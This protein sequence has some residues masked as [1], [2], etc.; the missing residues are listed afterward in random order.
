[1]R[2]GAR[3]ARDVI[4][5]ALEA[6][7]RLDAILH[8]LNGPLDTA[9]ARQAADRI[10][11][12]DAREPAN[13]IDP[14]G[15]RKAAGGALAGVPFLVKA[16]TAA[17]APIVARLRA[18][19]AIPIGVST[20][21]RPGTDSQTHGWNGTGFTRNPWD[22]AR[23]PGGSSAGAAAAVAAGV[24]P[25]ATGGDSG[26][27]LRIPAAFC[28]VT[29]F[30]G[31]AGRIPRPGRAVVDLA[32]AGLIGADLDD[33]VAATSLVS[34]PDRLDPA[35]LPGWPV[36]EPVEAPRVGYLATFGGPGDRRGRGVADPAVDAVV[37]SRLSAA[38]ITPVEVPFE[39]PDPGDAWDVFAALDAGRA[40]PD[41]LL[42]PAIAA[43][44]RA[45]A[46]VWDLFEQ[47]DALVTPTTL[48]V[49]HPFD[50]PVAGAPFVGDLCW[51]FN[52]TGNPA[53]SVPAGLVDGLPV[54]VQVVA[55]HG[56]DDIVVSLGRRLRAE[57]P[58]AP[59]HA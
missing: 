3:S 8:F 34:G 43:R 59:H 49:A 36:P 12:G 25:L 4:D 33:V 52:L 57:L 19:G 37:R 16:G 51:D 20:R 48:T 40:V 14:G 24:V 28:G 58:Q 21:N 35:A 29:G 56:R 45:D 55:A 5:E 11:A 27:S 17:G 39:L 32:V 23:S 18:A 50:G 7:A 6:A 46:A 10:D 54:G 31:T 1:M 9:G 53:I 38:G 2:S 44:R 47:V 22:L 41:A 13:R 26:G 15:A 42:Q 30:K